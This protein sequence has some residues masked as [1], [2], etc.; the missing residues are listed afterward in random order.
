MHK[1][2]EEV[3]IALKNHFKKYLAQRKTPRQLDC[4]NAVKKETSLKKISWGQVKHAITN[5]NATES[6]RLKNH[7][8]KYGW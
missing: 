4:L 3:K 6:R 2:T 7:L 8:N 1:W 5:L